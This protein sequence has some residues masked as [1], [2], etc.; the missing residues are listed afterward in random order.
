[1]PR[2]YFSKP[3][4]CRECN[5][6]TEID[7]VLPG[8]E[9]GND[10]RPYYKCKCRKMIL[11]GDHRGIHKRNPPCYCGDTTPSRLQAEG[12]DYRFRLV[13]RCQDRDCYFKEQLGDKEYTQVEILALA[14]CDM[15]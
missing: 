3:P 10:N 11:W 6:I 12:G 13:F 9:K 4:R 15:I 7:R 1:M 14:R 2:K 5:H 8:N